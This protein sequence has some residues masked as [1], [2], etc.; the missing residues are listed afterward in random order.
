MRT[1][2]TVATGALA[3]LALAGPLGA[4][5]AARP[6]EGASKPVAL[7][8]GVPITEAEGPRSA[9]CTRRT[10]TRWAP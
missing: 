2:M 9:P 7:V 4:A 3:T 5:E 8:G 10:R 1:F 6:A